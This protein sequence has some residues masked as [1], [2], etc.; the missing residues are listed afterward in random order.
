MLLLA[1]LC[2]TWTGLGA[3]IDYQTGPGVTPVLSVRLPDDRLS[4]P[5]IR[6]RV[7]PRYPDDGAAAGLRGFIDMEVVVDQKGGVAQARIAKPL[8]SDLDQASLDLVKQWLFRPAAD[9]QGRPVTMLMILRIEF[10]PPTQAGATGGVSASLLRP[11][12]FVQPTAD[13]FASAIDPGPKPPGLQNPKAL[14]GIMPNY[15][16]DAM[17]AKIQ[18]VVELHAVVLPDGTVG[19]IRVVKSLDGQHGLDQQA[20]EAAARWL[21]EP[22]TLNGA[23]VPVKVTLVLEFRLH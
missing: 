12:R 16:P 17:R 19:A 5:E 21:F 15:T 2:V 1:L 11:P 7:L 4:P 8:R 10:T 14:R 20:I 6:K 18:G 23:A 13:L 22:A 9:P 3:G